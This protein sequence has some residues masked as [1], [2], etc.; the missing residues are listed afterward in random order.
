MSQYTVTFYPENI[1]VVAQEGDNLLELAQQSDVLLTSSCGGNGICGKCK[2][3]IR[4]G[5]VHAEPTKF[6]DR[7]ERQQNYVLACMTLVH[8]D[9]EVEI[10]PESRLEDEQ[11]LIGQEEIIEEE[12]EREEVEFQPQLSDRAQFP[13]IFT[14]PFPSLTAKLHLSLSPPTIQDSADDLERLFREIRRGRQIPI[15]QVGLANLKNL[16]KFLRENNWALTVLLGKRG[17]TTE[18]ILMEAGDTSAKNYGVAVDIGTTTIAAHLVDLHA[19]KTIGTAATGNNQRE[20][21]ADV[22]TRIIYAA[23]KNGL[24]ILHKAVIDDINGLI[25]SLTRRNKIDIND[26]TCVM[27]AGNATMTHLFLGVDPTYI[28]REPYVPTANFFPVIRAAEAGIRINRRGLLSCMPGVSSYVGGDITAGALAS[29]ISEAEEICLFIDIGTNGEMVLG[30]KEWLVCCSCSCGPAFEGSGIRYGMRA[31]RGAIQRVTISG[32][33]Y[34]VKYST[35]ENDRPRGI[36]GSGLIDALGEMF[37][38]GVI[39]RSGRIQPNWNTP[40]YQEGEEGPEFILAWKEETSGGLGDI[41]IA[42]PDIDNL[43]RSKA[44]VYAAVQVMMEKMGMTWDDVEYVYIAGGFGNY[45]NIEKSVLIGLI[46]DLPLEKY[47]F[48][49][50]SSIAG[51]KM[52]ML[53][54]KSLARAEEIANKMTYIELSAD[55]TFMEQFTAATFLPHTAMSLFPSVEKKLKRNT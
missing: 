30:N 37:R 4:K 9:L 54:T 17:G 45:L 38:A 10:P 41:V 47:R 21:G 44:A 32:S 18:L 6:I 49:G 50:N 39:D 11:F 3:I 24:D 13:L 7:R 51:A 15:M 16:G 36:C 26:V 19:R 31:G 46:P 8:S 2:V 27:C 43:M 23:E 35:I 1:Q 28:R 20:H 12:L 55:N 42:Q 34:D 25:V 5:D 48:I 29:G 53:S 22:I 14:Y 33:N 40:R 52:A